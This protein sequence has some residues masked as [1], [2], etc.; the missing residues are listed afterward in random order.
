MEKPYWDPERFLL[1]RGQMGDLLGLAILTQRQAAKLLGMSR[2][3]IINFETGK[4]VIGRRT[5]LAC[6][7]ILQNGEKLL[8]KQPGEYL[9]DTPF[10]RLSTKL[11]STKDVQALVFEAE[12]ADAEEDVALAGCQSLA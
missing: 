5:A 7:F 8:E 9:D 12:S 4:T 1:W 10:E 6:N 3:Q 2:E 11:A